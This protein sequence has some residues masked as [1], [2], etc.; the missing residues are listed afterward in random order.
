MSQ[1]TPPMPNFPPPAPPAKRSHTNTIII[2]SAAA[3]I[4][5]IV[6]VGAVV[7]NDDSSSKAAPQ[8]TVTVTETETVEM[9]DQEIVD[10][11]LEIVESASADLEEGIEPDITVPAAETPVEEEPVGPLTSI[12]EGTYLVGED[13]KAGSYKTAGPTSDMCYWARRSDDSGELDAII[14]N[15]IVKGPG[16][17]TLKK[18]EFFETNS[19]ETW[20]LVK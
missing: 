3:A 2:G 1:P 8:P 18:G 10:R 20:E 19:C 6:I 12:G 11:G 15:D 16:R 13:V 17:V 14:A 5:V 7:A 4:S 9:T